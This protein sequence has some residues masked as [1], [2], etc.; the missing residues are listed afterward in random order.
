MDENRQPTLYCGLNNCKLVANFAHRCNQSQE[1]LVARPP[2]RCSLRFCEKNFAQSLA[3]TRT[4]KR[5][6]FRLGG[7]KLDK[8]AHDRH[9]PQWSKLRRRN[10]TVEDKFA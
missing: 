9:Q 1:D 6:A 8:T 5:G 7:I 2:C 10:G 3:R 4:E